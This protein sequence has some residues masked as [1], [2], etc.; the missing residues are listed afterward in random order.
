[1]FNIQFIYGVADDHKITMAS[2][3]LATYQDGHKTLKH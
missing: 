3:P 2:L 1:M